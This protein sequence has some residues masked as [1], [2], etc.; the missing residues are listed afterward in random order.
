MLL[1]SAHLKDNAALPGNI[2]HADYW[3]HAGTLALETQSWLKCSLSITGYPIGYHLSKSLKPTS[4][5]TGYSVLNHRTPVSGE[6][7]LERSAPNRL[8]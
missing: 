7:Q 4:Y 1:E 3:S 5:Q 8:N 2:I 6:L